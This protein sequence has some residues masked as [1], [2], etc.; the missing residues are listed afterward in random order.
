MGR[1]TRWLAGRWLSVLM[2][3]AVLL[4]ATTA[5]A[6]LTELYIPQN[7][8]PGSQG[9]LPLVQGTPGT[10]QL[11]SDSFQ[12][13][14]LADEATQHGY[15]RFSPVALDTATGFM[16]TFNLRVDGSTTSSTNRGGFSLVLVG[17]D[18]AKSLELVFSSN[19]VFA[20]DYNG[21]DPDRFVR[22]ASTSLMANVPYS[23]VL[24]VANDAYN[25][26]INGQNLLSGSLV[27]YTGQGLPY[28][29]PNFVFF[30]DDTSRASA[31]A[32]LGP[33]VLAS[34]VPEPARAWLWLPGLL[35]LAGWLGARRRR[36]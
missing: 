24:T 16:L 36:Q 14:T 13:N 22:G 3:A 23:Y 29:T 12:L 6:Q 9:W 32:Y 27:D 20:Y 18:P 5:Q 15:F 25:L 11:G 7:G 21:G 30:G 4:G 28:T 35:L 1:T 8:T 19:E 26:N 17:N 33:L 10:T 34:T 31:N 2:G